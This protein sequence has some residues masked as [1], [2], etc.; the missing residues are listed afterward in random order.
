MSCKCARRTGC[1]SNSTYMFVLADHM[2]IFH[3]I[4]CM[5]KT[6]H[7]SNILYVHVL[8]DTSNSFN[9]TRRTQCLQVGLRKLRECLLILFG[10]STPTGDVSSSRIIMIVCVWTTRTRFFSLDVCHRHANMCDYKFFVWVTL[11]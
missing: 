11:P 5:N 9:S 1:T 8:A 2:R 4:G 10:H 3:L 6:Y 7:V